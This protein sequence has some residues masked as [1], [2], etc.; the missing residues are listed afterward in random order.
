MI[1]PG[2]IEQP[3]STSCQRLCG[4]ANTT[5]SLQVIRIVDKKDRGF[6]RV[7][8]PGERLFFEAPSDAQLEVLSTYR[9]QAVKVE[10]LPCLK[11]QVEER[12]LLGR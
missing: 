11:L 3:T 2:I 1:T 5:R 7:I 12:G 8:F 4:Y 9:G 10:T 6:E